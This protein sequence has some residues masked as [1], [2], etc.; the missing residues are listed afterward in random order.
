MK[1][2][3]L[4]VTKG[5]AGITPIKDLSFS[6]SSGSFFLTG[7]SGCGKSTLLN[8]AAGLLQPEEGCVIQEGALSY[9]FQEDRLLPWFSALKNVE[10]VNKAEA[11]PLLGELGLSGFMHLQPEEL[12]GGMCRRVAL[13]RALAK[14][15]DIYLFDEPFTGL[16]QTNKEKAAALIWEK[17]KGALRLFVLH[18]AQDASLIEAEPLSLF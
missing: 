4:N 8:L 6:L 14:K 13:A 2:Q 5:F 15:S 1:L 16:D 9:L 7:P 3:F 12:S 11:A 10:L 18:G 17:T